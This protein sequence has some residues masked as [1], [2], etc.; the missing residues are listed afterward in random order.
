MNTIARL[1]NRFWRWQYTTRMNITRP[2]RR[3]WFDRKRANARPIT[4]HFEGFTYSEAE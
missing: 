2:V 4:L 1:Y 3:W